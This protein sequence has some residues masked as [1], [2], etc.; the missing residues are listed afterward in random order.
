MTD[1]FTK[2]DTWHGGFYELALELGSRS[3][4]RLHEALTIVW[5]YPALQG[6]YL[7]RT[8]EPGQQV[9]VSVEP[10]MLDRHV[11]GLAHLPN[12]VQVA[13]G[14]CSIRL[15]GDSDWL[16]IYLPM[17]ALSTVYPTGG[18]PFGDTST[19]SV[20]QDTLDEWLKQLGYAVYSLVPFKLGLIGHEASMEVDAAQVTHAGVPA[21]RPIGYLWPSGTQL[22]YFARNT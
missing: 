13:C 20:W 3:D 5:S 12:G 7:D 16:I 22:H 19:S 4:A 17:G 1:Y 2:K 18:Y 10:F 21:T 6:A 15:D 14:T 8:T 9:P 11:Y